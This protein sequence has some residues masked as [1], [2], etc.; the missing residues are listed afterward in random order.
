ML[1]RKQHSRPDDVDVS[2]SRSQVTA[3]VGMMGC[4][5]RVMR[6]KMRS[7]CSQR[8]RRSREYEVER[9]TSTLQVGHGVKACVQKMG[10]QDQ[11]TLGWLVAGR[12]SHVRG[13]LHNQ[14]PE[15]N[16]FDFP[17]WFQREPIITKNVFSFCPGGLSK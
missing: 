2:A 17:C 1:C 14:P 6:M 13:E 8:A 10:S 5:A 7:R 15:A 9:P 3:I 16:M 4:S 12:R 11:S